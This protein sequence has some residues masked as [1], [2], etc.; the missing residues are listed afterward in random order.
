MKHS[1]YERDISSHSHDELL[2]KLAAG[3]SSRERTRLA[4]AVRHAVMAR[5]RDPQQRPR[6]L[7]VAHILLGLGV[8]ALT[9]QAALLS[10]PWLREN[11]AEESIKSQFG[12]PVASLVQKVN[13]LNT[14]NEYTAEVCEPEQAELLRRM[15]LAVVNDV[16]A[17]LVKL[18]YRLQRLR[19]LKHE[20]DPS[21]RYRIARETLDLF[22][23]LANRLGL[24]Q[25][26]WELEDLSFRYL[27]PDAY[28]NLAT[29][30]D[31]KRA[32]REKYIGHFIAL[33]DKALKDNGIDAQIYGRPKHL[34][35]I[36]SKMRRKHL[37][38]DDLYDLL[39]VRVIV[40][41]PASCYAVLGIVHNEWLHVPKEFDDYIAN[42]KD[43]GYQS[44]HTVVVGPEGRSVEVQI[45][46]REM[47]DFAEHGV[48]AHW[49]YK[50]G[51]KQDAALDRSINS[52]RRLLDSRNDD[53]ALLEDFR[54]EL[55]ADQI[56]VLTPKG[57]VIRL[58][59]GATPLDFAYAIHSEIGHRCRGAKVNGHIVPLSHALNSG[60][61]VEILTAKHGGPSLGWLDP[62]MGYVSTPN[63]RSKIKQWFKQQDH[64]KHL[65]A[66]RALLERERHKL[67]LPG[68]RDS[69]L[70]ELARHFHLSRPDDLLLAIGRAEIG[71]A[72]LAAT[73][74]VPGFHTAPVQPATRK[75]EFPATVEPDQVTVQ[76][77]RNLLTHFATCCQPTPGTPII[78]YITVGRG[79][80][81]HRQDCENIL[82]LPVHKQARLIE[83]GWGEEATTFPVEI[84][85]QAIDR[86]GLL[87]DV[88][89]ILAQE[90]INIL[91]TDTRTDTH[92]QSV[93]MAITL[94]VSDIGQLSMALDKLE[95]V[96]NVLQARRKVGR[97]TEN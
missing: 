74:Q 49:R 97:R 66:G 58:K 91:R 30:L 52:L 3:F 8:D 43:N 23:P 6:G 34:F 15:L 94:E 89:H 19:S 39:A 17:V 47:H 4:E 80:A 25:L 46:T 78:G 76:G 40:D 10:D 28:K 72:Q 11:L 1:L 92:N 57:Q 87:K 50:E 73:L 45:R 51:G 18:A 5:D 82:N 38:L 20:Q 61:K 29:S 65:R 53:Q 44:L 63:A 90:H 59:K 41:K 96:H 13:W 2:E 75:H 60:E 37:A 62:H 24:G 69:D 9:V 35:S 70:D 54:S 12:E 71:Q 36:W 7:D 16:R 26:K 64:E 79:V 83:V 32:E 85:V 93:T 67:G 22:S 95:Q 48:A 81:I 14:F 88:T 68:L 21:V 33:L 84:E 55:F 27:E 42:P 31:G 77:V 86:K 56:F